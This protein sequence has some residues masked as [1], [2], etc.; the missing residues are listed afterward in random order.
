MNLF[1][2]GNLREGM[3]SHYILNGAISLGKFKVNIGYDMVDL[4][5]YPGLVKYHGEWPLAVTLEGYRVSKEV[6]THLFRQTLDTEFVAQRITV[7]DIDGFIFTL[8]KAGY[9]YSHKHLVNS[10][11]W[12]AYTKANQFYCI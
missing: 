7:N 3:P 8:D 10:G 2:Y 4:G 5:G 11:D 12:K 9:Y 1:V 6:M